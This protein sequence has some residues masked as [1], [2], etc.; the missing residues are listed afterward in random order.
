MN[1]LRQVWEI[2]LFGRSGMIRFESSKEKKKTLNIFILYFF[3]ALTGYATARSGR[4]EFQFTLGEVAFFVWILVTDIDDHLKGFL[5]DATVTVNLA[6]I[7]SG[8]KF[9]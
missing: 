4:V 2:D 5:M 7:T 9:S 1:L 8:S 6:L 3:Q